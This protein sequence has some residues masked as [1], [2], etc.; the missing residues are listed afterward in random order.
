[1]LFVHVFLAVCETKG[2][3]WSFNMYETLICIIMRCVIT[4]IYTIKYS[5]L[6]V[7]SLYF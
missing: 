2:D 5:I 4:V 7:Y 6:I 1:M 3:R